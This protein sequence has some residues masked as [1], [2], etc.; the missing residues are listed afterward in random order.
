MCRYILISNPCGCYGPIYAD[1][2]DLC[3][4][5]LEQLARINE[6]EAWNENTVDTV[7]FYLPQHCEPGWHNTIILPSYEPC[8]QAWVNCPAVTNPLFPYRF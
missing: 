2:D 7:P 6:A 8:Y 4:L 3:P 5:V 1:P